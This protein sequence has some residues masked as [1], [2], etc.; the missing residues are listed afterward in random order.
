MDGRTLEGKG[1]L[2]AD[3]HVVLLGDC[4]AILDLAGEVGGGKRRIIQLIHG[5]WHGICHDH[6]SAGS[7]C[8]AENGGGHGAERECR[9][10]VCCGRDIPVGLW[11]S[12]NDCD[13]VGNAF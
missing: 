4:E 3:R 12:F 11:C 2:I 13:S 9:V 8:H 7:G 1:L 10:H 5:I 6:V